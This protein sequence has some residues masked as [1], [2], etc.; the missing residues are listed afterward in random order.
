MLLPFFGL[1][2]PLQTVMQSMQQLGDFHMT[3]WMSLRGEKF[4]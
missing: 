4:G 3:D 2:I 1:G